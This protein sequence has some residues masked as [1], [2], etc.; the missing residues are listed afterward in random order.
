MIK[1]KNILAIM[2]GF[3]VFTGNVYANPEENETQ[4]QIEDSEELEENDD[5]FTE[6]ERDILEELSHLINE[7]KIQLLDNQIN[8]N[9]I[10]YNQV[11]ED[12]EQRNIDIDKKKIEIVD[13]QKELKA[14][15][16]NLELAGTTRPEN[17]LKL[18]EF[19]LSSN[20][21]SDLIKNIE[22]GS[23]LIK[24]SNRELNFLEL[25]EE[26]LKEMEDSL[27]KESEELKE[28][29]IKLEEDRI[30][31]DELK[32][33]VEEEIRRE[34]ERLLLLAQEQERLRQA[35]LLYEEQQVQALSNSSFALPTNT[36]A[37]EKAQSI[38]NYAYQF[39][40]IPYVWGG[41]TPNGFDCS[42]FTSYVY[43]AFGINIPRVARDQQ[44][45]GQRISLS[46]VLPGD[47]VFFNTPATHVGIYVGN[48]QYIHAPRTGDV[49]RV[50]NLNWGAV[51]SATRVIF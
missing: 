34:Q 8:E 29:K 28:L 38:L 49:I 50:A 4:L 15:R 27:I 26:Q 33:E 23:T 37:S 47:M 51:S 9:Q 20:S 45:F 22:L 36:Y 11:E 3:L 7:E 41:S 12:I 40:G 39:R 10:A 42:G 18:F 1:R 19:V 35:Q 46:E 17:S 16:T 25:E 44:N 21:F 6:E 31:L 13:K 24:E 48:N 30:L 2:I 5:Y 14:K 32:L 43:R